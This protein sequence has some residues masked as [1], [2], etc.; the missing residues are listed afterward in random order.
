MAPNAVLVAFLATAIV[1]A[2]N[3]L[4]GLIKPVRIAGGSN[5]KKGEFPYAVSL[6]VPNKK[7]NL[8]HFCTGSLLDAKT[9]LTAAHCVEPVWYSEKFYA[10][11]VVVRAGS[12]VS[13]VLF[14]YQGTCNG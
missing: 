14:T 12:L 1:S 2:L 13:I 4:P 7:G 9:V 5:A 10:E 11:D 8:T 6:Q 3:P